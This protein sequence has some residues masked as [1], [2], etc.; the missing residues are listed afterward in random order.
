MKHIMP[1][2]AISLYSDLSGEDTIE[3]N[4]EFDPLMF[5]LYEDMGIN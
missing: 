3:I 2:V 5:Y 4:L 1:V